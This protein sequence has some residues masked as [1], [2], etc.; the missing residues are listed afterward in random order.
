M[1][2]FRR[3]LAVPIAL[4]LAAVAAAPAAAHQADPDYDSVLTGVRPAAAGLEVSVLDRGDRLALRN[5][6]PHLIEIPGYQDEP[7]LRLLPNGAVEENERSP[8][9]YLNDDPKGRS[10]VPASADAKADPVWRTI[11]RAGRIE[12]HDHR[13]HWMG[14]KRPPQVTDPGRRTKVY[15]WKVPIRV[16]GRPAAIDGTLFWTPEEESSVPLP[17]IVA[18]AVL[19]VAAAAT[20][21]VVRRRRAAD[22]GVAEREDAW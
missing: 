22:G 14:A 2:C 10:T 13:I 7:Y 6:G 1:P 18:L 9:A 3:S 19:L 4:L 8:A 11:D 21:V 17:A 15:D 16:D 20:V 5:G 12:F